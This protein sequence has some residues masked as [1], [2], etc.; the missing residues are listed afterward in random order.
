MVIILLNPYYQRKTCYE[1]YTCVQASCNE[2]GVIFVY[3][4]FCSF[5]YFSCFFSSIQPWISF[6]AP[7]EQ[8]MSTSSSYL[9]FEP[10][11]IQTMFHSGWLVFQLI[12]Q[13][14][15]EDSSPSFKLQCILL[16]EILYMYIYRI[17]LSMIQQDVE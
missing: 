4:N 12:Y 7:K 10:G 8:I 5:K 17:L 1:T 15:V 11:E 2:S 14:Q 6:L 13:L 9:L 3:V 16:I